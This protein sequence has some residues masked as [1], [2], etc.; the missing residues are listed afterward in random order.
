[1]YVISVYPRCNNCSLTQSLLSP[2]PP[3][4]F[5]FAFLDVEANYFIVLAY[6]HTTI[7]SI[8]LLNFTAIVTVVVLSFSFLK[9]RYRPPQIAGIVICCAGMGVLI[10]SDTIQRS[11]NNPAPDPNPVKGDLFAL[12]A[13]TLYGMT[14][15]YEEFALSQRPLYEVIGQLAFWGSLVS[16]VQAAIFDRSTVRHATWSPVSVGYLVGYTLCLSLFYSLAP[17]LFRLASAAVFNIGNL[18]ANFWAVLIGTRVFGMSVHWMYPPAFVLI[19]AG[20]VVYF[21]AAKEGVFADSYKPWL[22]DKQERGINGIGT[23]RRR[24]EDPDTVV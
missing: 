10:A 16:G 13:A 15:T 14:N 5:I 18:T 19:V 11:N 9:V 2:F 21:V 22:G 24:V 1:M 17:I 6:R 4:D 12:L 23:A 7:L 20:L 3:P 8:Q